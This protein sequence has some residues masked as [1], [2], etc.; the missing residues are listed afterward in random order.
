[1]A[2]AFKL[3][4]FIYSGIKIL[5]SLKANVSEQDE[6]LLGGKQILSKTDE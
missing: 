2:L 3:F 5:D 4:K 6:K 1:M